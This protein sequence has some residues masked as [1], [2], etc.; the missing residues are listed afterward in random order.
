MLQT[1]NM[2]ELVLTTSGKYLITQEKIDKVV[3]PVK[4]SL[5]VAGVIICIVLGIY[6][7]VKKYWFW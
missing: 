7:R 1:D 4:E 2:S 6:I 5:I 3:L